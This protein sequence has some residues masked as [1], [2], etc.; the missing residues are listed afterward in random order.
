MKQIGVI[1][2]GN[3]LSHEEAMLD[4]HTS[5]RFT[6]DTGDAI[7]IGVGEWEPFWR[8]LYDGYGKRA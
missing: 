1:V 5:G 8:P 3:G 4:A 2:K 6:Q 7:V